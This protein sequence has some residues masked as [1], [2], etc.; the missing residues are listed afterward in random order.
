M[1]IS[2]PK[3]LLLL[4]TL[5]WIGI[6][7]TL[8]FNFHAA[9]RSNRSDLGQIDQ[10][11][12]NSSQGRFLENSDAGFIATRLT[13]HVEPI[14]VL[15]SPI[16]WL[17]NDVRALLLLQV[18]AVAAGAWFIWKIS[19]EMGGWGDGVLIS[20]SPHPPT[21]PSPYL[22][23]AFTVAYLLAPQLQHAVLTEF[24]AAPLAVPL[25]LWALW[26]VETRRTRQFVI[27]AL[28][29][30]CV[31]EEMAIAAAGLGVWAL[32]RNTK[33]EIRNTKE[34][35][36]RPPHSAFRIP[37]SA[38]RTILTLSPCHLV[39]FA[40]LAGFIIATVVFVPATAPLV[41]EQANSV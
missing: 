23:L 17:W 40:T 37:H 3:T 29:V 14:L 2:P 41:Y 5:A 4:L 30:A 33:Y 27:A 6:F 7:T 10:A 19:G 25:I 15:I 28:L 1:R 13:D 35:S 26:A 18:L 12:W 31:K 24:H 8:A 36:L 20:P 32:Y 11:V 9:L 16:F 22:P 39:I 34:Q 38:L 21:S